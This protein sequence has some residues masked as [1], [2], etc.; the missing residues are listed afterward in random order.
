MLNA[1]NSITTKMKEICHMG[2]ACT[3]WVHAESGKLGLSPLKYVYN[4]KSR[5]H[6]YKHKALEVLKFEAKR[7]ERIAGMNKIGSKHNEYCWLRSGRRGKVLFSNPCKRRRRNH[8]SFALRKPNLAG[9]ESK[10][11]TKRY[12][13][14]QNAFFHSRKVLRNQ[15]QVV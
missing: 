13:D 12:E 5:C 15:N 1:E 3:A 6:I 10:E 9:R 7:H 8:I 11:R 4:R 14:L 2:G